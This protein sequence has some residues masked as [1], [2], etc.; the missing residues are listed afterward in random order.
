VRREAQ[1]AFQKTRSRMNSQQN[2]QS[3]QFNEHGKKIL[4]YERMK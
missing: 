3:A 4:T 1:K 2:K